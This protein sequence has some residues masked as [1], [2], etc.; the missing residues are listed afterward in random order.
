MAAYSYLTP[1][2]MNF[3]LS[4]SGIL[5]CRMENGEE[6]PVQLVRLFPFAAPD[7]Y[8]S[9]MDGETELGI[10]ADLAEL[11]EIQQQIVRDYLSYKYFI[12]PIT[13]IGKVEEKLGY[14]YMAVETALGE[15][16]I[17]IADPTSN[18]RRV[19]KTYVSIVD[20][21]GNRYCIPDLELLPRQTRQKIEMFF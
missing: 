13:Q 19:G 3:T 6:K 5:S 9:V 15:K 1:S 18:I 10:L 4:D 12:P 16:T 21:Q 17:C 11:P 8:I 2:S 7:Q 14:V 20:V